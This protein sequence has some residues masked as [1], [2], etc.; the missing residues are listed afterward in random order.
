MKKLLALLLAMLMLLSTVA[1]VACQD[2]TPS[3]VV[4]PVPGDPEEPDDTT[5]E[6]S[7]DEEKANSVISRIEKIGDFTKAN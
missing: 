6:V 7:E 3:D 2:N 4:N 5:P 1:M